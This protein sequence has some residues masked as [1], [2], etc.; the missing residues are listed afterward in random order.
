MG[1]TAVKIVASQMTVVEAPGQGVYARSRRSF[2][3]S[4]RLRQFQGCIRSKMEG[5]SFGS[6]EAVHKAFADAA[7]S[8]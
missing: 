8:C 3:H 7:K 5:K 4:A 1:K 2:Q 6:R